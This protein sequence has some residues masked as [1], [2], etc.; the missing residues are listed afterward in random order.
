MRALV[1][2]TLQRKLCTKNAELDFWAIRTSLFVSKVDWLV[3][4]P[5]VF[6]LLSRPIVCLTRV[7]QLLLPFFCD[8]TFEFFIQT[9]QT[10]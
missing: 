5:L 3:S 1:S 6:I 4:Y 10:C 9:W 2:F 8:K 7:W